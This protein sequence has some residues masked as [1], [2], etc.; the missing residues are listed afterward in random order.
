M[1]SQLLNL[2]RVLD[3]GDYPTRQTASP[4]PGGSATAARTEV[5]YRIRG[6]SVQPIAGT[7]PPVF[8][9]QD[10]VEV[11]VFLVA[12]AGNPNSSESWKASWISQLPQ[13]QSTALLEHERLHYRLSAL[14]YRDM[15]IEFMYLKPVDYS[16]AQAG[17]DDV[18]TIRGRYSRANVMAVHGQYDSPQQTAHQPQT[19]P[20]AQSRWEGYAQAAITHRKPLFD[21]LTDDGHTLPSRTP[22]PVTVPV[23]YPRV[24]NP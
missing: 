15:F 2:L 7:N 20:Q 23:P 12:D 24:G 10:T 4:P 16:T 9:L 3:W 14:L 5:N 22:C 18:Q 11:E 19:N 13:G 6:V 1:P 21:V 8:K 17:I